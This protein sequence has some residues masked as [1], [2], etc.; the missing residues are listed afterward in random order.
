MNDIVC[1]IPVLFELDG[2]EAQ[3]DPC[4]SLG[5]DLAEL[6]MNLPEYDLSVGLCERIRQ[7]KEETGIEF[8]LHLPEETDAGW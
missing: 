8:T 4:R 3:V 7:M 6:N 5:L 2:L 1:G